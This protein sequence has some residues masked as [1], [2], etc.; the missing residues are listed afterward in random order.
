MTGQQWLEPQRSSEIVDEYKNI[1]DTNVSGAQ[2]SLLGQ[3][4]VTYGRHQLREYG[5][6]VV[7]EG[8]AGGFSPRN[9]HRDGGKLAS[10]TKSNLNNEHVWAKVH[11]LWINI[12]PQASLRQG[13]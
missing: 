4:P 12:L 2:A 11:C 9:V 13:H 1:S 10:V 3:T 6:T 5:K 7:A 8:K